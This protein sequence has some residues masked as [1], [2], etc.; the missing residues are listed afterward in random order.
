M[1]WYLD[2]KVDQRTEKGQQQK[3]FL[4]H[5]IRAAKAMSVILVD[6]VGQNRTFGKMY[7]CASR[8]QKNRITVDEQQYTKLDE[9]NIELAAEDQ[10]LSRKFED[11]I[12]QKE[13]IKQKEKKDEL[14]K[15]EREEKQKKEKEEEEKQGKLPRELAKQ[16]AMKEKVEDARKEQEAKEKLATVVG[17]FQKR[18]PMPKFAI[19]SRLDKDI[20]KALLVK[21]T[22]LQDFE[23]DDLK[24]LYFN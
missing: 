13:R 16:Q 24:D 2:E 10:G 3:E 8:R 20:L 9:K 23:L 12:K 17:L 4:E 1:Q 21:C 6:W 5:N 15:K 19:Y 22:E 14:T 11:Q 18:V 7:L